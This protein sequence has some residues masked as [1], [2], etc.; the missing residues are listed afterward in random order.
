[1]TC[2]FSAFTC[3]EQGA[4]S[5][6][7]A[8]Q[9]Q[10]LISAGKKGDVCIFD[11]RQRVLRHRF[12]A[13]ESAIK[14]L[15]ID[16]HEEHFVTGSAD[17]DIRVSLIFI[18]KMSLQIISL[19]IYICTKN[20]GMGF[21][22]SYIIVYVPRWACKEQ[23]LQAHRS[24]CNPTASRCSRTSIFMWCRWLNESTSTTRSWINRP[25]FVLN[26]KQTMYNETHTKNQ[27]RP[28]HV[29]AIRGRESINTGELTQTLTYLNKTNKQTK[30]THSHLKWYVKKKERRHFKRMQS[31]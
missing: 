16:P 4:S 20:K 7:Y 5:L 29:N 25:N 3:H 27:S 6:I 23:L 21:I 31:T 8:P 1:M 11:V 13:H 19:I 18:R 26:S 9:H 22:S 15:A 2:P 28:Q 30:Y 14:C 17:G 24:R 12:Q 10:L